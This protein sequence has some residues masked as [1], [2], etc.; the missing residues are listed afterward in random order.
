MPGAI[1]S[2]PEVTNISKHGLWLLAGGEELFL[3]FDEFPWFK[4]AAIKDILSVEEPTSGHFY[5][6]ALDVDLS[7]N[8]I[9]DPARYPLKSRTP[10]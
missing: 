1:I 5:W 4:D 7:I 3:S 6:P 9:R 2:D 10:R 8:V